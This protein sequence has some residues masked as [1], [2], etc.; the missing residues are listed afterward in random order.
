M[1]E[2]PVSL[3]ELLQKRF[4]LKH[5]ENIGLSSEHHKKYG[6]QTNTD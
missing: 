1:L 5:I 6:L 4:Y 3:S 2:I